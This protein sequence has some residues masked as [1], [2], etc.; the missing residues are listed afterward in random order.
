MQYPRVLASYKHNVQDALGV[1]DKLKTGL[2]IDGTGRVFSLPVTVPVESVR[3][4]RT[5]RYTGMANYSF[6]DT[7]QIDQ[8]LH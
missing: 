1:L 2:D 3:P 6:F 5:D 4:D 7:L 8:L